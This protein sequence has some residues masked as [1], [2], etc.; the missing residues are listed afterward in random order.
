[1]FR[2]I[3]S[4]PLERVRLPRD[5]PQPQRNVVTQTRLVVRNHSCA[6]QR[7]LSKFVL[8][9]GSFFQADVPGH[10][11]VKFLDN[12]F[13]KQTHGLL[14]SASLRQRPGAVQQVRASSI[15]HPRYTRKFFEPH[16]PSRSHFRLGPLGHFLAGVP[17][18]FLACFCLFLIVV[19]PSIFLACL[20]AESSNKGSLTR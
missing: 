17:P 1:M 13:I 19:L 12:V 6:K 14:D 9:P 5:L 20:G 2:R 16:I 3:S 10:Q 15:F 18:V 4:S 7:G 8:K 11:H